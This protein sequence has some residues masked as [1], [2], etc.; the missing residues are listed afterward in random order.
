MSMKIKEKK[1]VTDLEI[2]MTLRMT[3]LAMQL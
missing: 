2:R 3:F 1:L